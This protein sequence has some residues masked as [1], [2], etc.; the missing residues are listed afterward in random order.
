MTSSQHAVTPNLYRH[1]PELW[2]VPPDLQSIPRWLCWRAKLRQTGKLDKIPVTPINGATCSVTDENSSTEFT[3]AYSKA[4]DDPTISGIGFALFKDDNIIAGDLDNCIDPDGTYSDLATELISHLETYWEISPS[5]KGLRFMGRGM[6]DR[7]LIDH[8]M[9]L[10]IYN[11]KRY[12]TITGNAL[13]EQIFALED[14]QSGID[15]VVE[16]YRSN[17]SSQRPGKGGHPRP[18]VDIDKIKKSLER[19]DPNCGYHDWIK[20]GMALE[21]TGA[22]DAFHWFDEWSSKSKEKYPGRIE[23]RKKWESF[24]FDDGVGVGVGTIYWFA[25]RS[26]ASLSECSGRNVRMFIQKQFLSYS[27]RNRLRTDVGNVDRLIDVSAGNIRFVLGLEQWIGWTGH[28]W[29]MLPN[30]YEVT[31]YVARSIYVEAQ[32]AGDDE[33]VKIIQWGLTSQA[34]SRLDALSEL[35]KQS[36][37]IMLPSTELDSSSFLLGVSNGTVD[38]RT[39]CLLAPERD[40]F[41][42]KSTAV[43][44]QKNAECPR[45]EE[46]LSEIT[47]SDA[48]LVQFLQRLAGY[49]LLGGN[50]EQVVVI[51]HGW[52]S[53]GKSTFVSVIQKILGDYCRQVDPASLMVKRNQSAGGA[54]E[55]LVRLYRTRLAIAAETGHG[56]KLDESLI[57]SLSGGDVITA[58][59]LYAKNALEFQPEFLLLLATNNRPT[60]KGMD[61]A[62]WRRL[63]LIPFERT[64]KSHEQDKQLYSNLLAEGEGVLRWMIEGCRLW[65]NSPEGLHPPE[66]V[67]VATESYRAEMDVFADWIDQACVRDSDAVYPITDLYRAYK[68]W[69]EKEEVKELDAR[70]FGRNLETKGFPSFKQ[71]GKRM[72]RGLRL[73]D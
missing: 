66:C 40:R 48:E 4:L 68:R 21:S 24:A 47:N 43:A 63:V 33:K 32:E 55:D 56:D 16:K 19:I 14:I 36:E 22:N 13:P 7:P 1:L 37:S 30:S 12:V 65:H 72:R 53:N 44:Y 15:S 58:R 3:M 6:L 9:G 57:K 54:R 70:W 60:I 26:K 41:I 31:S 50:P 5:G 39:G 62:I 34:K 61:H 29:E 28:R 67:Q 8:R 46:F 17:A 10:E 20:I 73:I 27:D 45:W 11:E 25:E 49:A 52:G 23:C 69:C 2:E 38:L 42:S 18:I 64:F 35:A 59:G 51:L 71:S